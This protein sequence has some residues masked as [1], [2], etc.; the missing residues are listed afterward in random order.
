MQEIVPFDR[1]F[2]APPSGVV[3]DSDYLSYKDYES[4][5]SISIDNVV[6]NERNKELYQKW[7]EEKK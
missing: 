3:K 1:I 5:T 6:V 4:V 2:L 7:K